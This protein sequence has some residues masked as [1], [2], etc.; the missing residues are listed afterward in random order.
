MM[1][2][3]V[4]RWWYPAAVV[5]APVVVLV[6]WSTRASPR[7]MVVIGSMLFLGGAAGL[8][9]GLRYLLLAL[10]PENSSDDLKELGVALGVVAVAASAALGTWGLSLC[11]VGMRR[12]RTPSS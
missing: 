4:Q 9:A 5:V 7:A 10:S 2:E 6:Y 11:G 8:A 12:R 3:A 1:V